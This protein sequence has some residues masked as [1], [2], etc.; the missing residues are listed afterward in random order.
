MGMIQLQKYNGVDWFNY[1]VSDIKVGDIFRISPGDY[2]E[3]IATR[4]EDD[5]IVCDRFSGAQSC[6]YAKDGKGYH[7]SHMG[8]NGET[9]GDICGSCTKIVGYRSQGCQCNG[10]YAVAIKTVMTKSRFQGEEND[11]WEALLD[12]DDK[13]GAHGAGKGV[14]DAPQA[15]R[16]EGL[17]EAPEEGGQGSLEARAARVVDA[18][19]DK[20]LPLTCHEIDFVRKIVIRELQGDDLDWLEDAGQISHRVYAGGM[21]KLIDRVT[22]KETNLGP[23]G[24]PEIEISSSDERPA[25]PLAKKA[26]WS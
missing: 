24:V 17:L 12:G 20:G 10:K 23:V 3:N 21:A 5:V 1:A 18:M 7:Y 4:I 8:A 15:V 22:G 25:E 2:I 6:G 16:Q 13:E 14:V 19:H 26:D 11:S 9:A